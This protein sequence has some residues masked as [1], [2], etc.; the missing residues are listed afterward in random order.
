MPKKMVT[1]T[2]GWS[3]AARAASLAAR[4]A[5][6]KGPRRGSIPIRRIRAQDEFISKPW[7]K[8]QTIVRPH[9]KNV[10]LYHNTTP[11]RAKKLIQK[12]FQRRYGEAG[13]VYFSD[14]KRGS[15]TFFG[16]STVKVTVPRK[17]IPRGG[18]AHQGIRSKRFANANVPIKNPKWETHKKAETWFEIPSKNLKGVKVTRGARTRASAGITGTTKT[19]RRRK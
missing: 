9:G 16:R 7:V 19:R 12:G 18:T 8:M 15:A 10:V 11:A 5:K 2:R 4:R 6:A 14:V 13:K 1:G 3:D 17:A